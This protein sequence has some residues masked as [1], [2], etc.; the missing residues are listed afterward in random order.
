[1]SL[2]SGL[3]LSRDAARWGMRF[4]VRHFWVVAGFSM[5]PTIQRF[6]AVRWGD[7]LP[8]AV[9]GATEVLTGAVRL[10]LIYTIYK[11][12]I[13]RDP[14]LA[15][16][17]RLWQ[18]LAWFVD[19]RRANFLAQFLVLGAAFAVFDVLPNA[20][21]QTWVAEGSR[22]WVS[23]VLVSVKNPTV[24]AFTFIWMMGVARQMILAADLPETSAD[25][26]KDGAGERGGEIADVR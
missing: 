6:V 8:A 17:D 9:N 23:A 18:R 24:I 11:L 1:M 4:Y 21:V 15:Q 12:A 14:E 13:A 2:P 22:E 20:A 7:D 3:L 26:D 10:L 19:H 5:I 16:L 25:A